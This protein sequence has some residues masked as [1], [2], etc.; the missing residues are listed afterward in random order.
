MAKL[1]I[2]R[3]I[4]LVLLCLLRSLISEGNDGSNSI[5][6]F[7]HMPGIHRMKM[8]TDTIPVVIPDTK[9]P[10]EN[11]PATVKPAIIKEVPKSRRQVKPVTLPT[12]PVKPI[13]VIKPTVIKRVIGMIG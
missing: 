11:V 1:F 10:E 13:K 6:R 4:F 8:V 3:F 5:N 7:R 12:V 9:K 2:Q